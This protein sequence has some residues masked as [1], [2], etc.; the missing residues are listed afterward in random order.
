MLEDRSHWSNR[1]KSEQLVVDFHMFA[2]EITT[3]ACWIYICVRTKSTFLLVK[4]SHLKPSDACFGDH[5]CA[6][7]AMSADEI[8]CQTTACGSS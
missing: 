4:S 2:V 8:D 6:K 1:L 7:P 5:P 3:F